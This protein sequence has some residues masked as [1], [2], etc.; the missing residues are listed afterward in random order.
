MSILGWLRILHKLS[1]K[2]LLRNFLAD[3]RTT[4]DD[5]LRDTLHVQHDDVNGSYNPTQNSTV[6][7]M[8]GS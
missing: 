7:Y 2:L 1:R 3:K 4:D 8:I 5:Y 6:P